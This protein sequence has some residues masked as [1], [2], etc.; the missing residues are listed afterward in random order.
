MDYR[1]ERERLLMKASKAYLDGSKPTPVALVKEILDKMDLNPTYK[2]LV[3]FDHIFAIELR[4]RGCTDITLACTTPNPKMQSWANE[5][6]YRIVTFKDIEDMKFDVV[7]GNPPFED[8]NNSGVKL[9]RTFL[10]LAIVIGDTVA[11]I[12]PNTWLAKGDKTLEKVLNQTSINFIDVRSTH[13]KDVYFR[14][15]GSTF[16]YFILDKNNTSGT[17]VRYIDGEVKSNVTAW[18][19][20]P[21]E[22]FIKMVNSS[23]TVSI[24]DKFFA[25]N[26]NTIFE[27]ETTGGHST[28][29][30]HT[31]EET[32]TNKVPCFCTTVEDGHLHFVE[33]ETPYHNEKKVF[34]VSS[35][36]NNRALRRARYVATPCSN[37]N[38]IGYVLVSTDEE[39]KGVENFYNSNLFRFVVGFASTKRDIPIPL[40]KGIGITIATDLY[41]HFNLT[42][43]EIDLVE[44]SIKE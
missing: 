14:G 33:E 38:N 19:F 13:I 30:K 28:R 22:G 12:T 16:C 27:F 4:A 24:L 34:V 41:Q 11:L 26:G 6:G 9:Y 43:E 5:I 10:E 25:M 39:G 40:L 44:S 18:G 1:Y 3:M 23:L 29:V 15:I 21:A 42:Q 17:T 36:F 32:D 8:P 31:F 35:Y 37:M 2:Y 7:V 20:I